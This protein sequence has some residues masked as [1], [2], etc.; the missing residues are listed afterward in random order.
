[1]TGT[2]MKTRGAG[3]RILRGGAVV[4]VEPLPDRAPD[5]IDTPYAAAV[6]EK[7]S[8]A[9]A[10]GAEWMYAG[11]SPITFRGCSCPSP[12]FCTDWYRRSF[13]PEAYRHSIA[14]LD[15]NGN[16][17]MHIGQYGNLDSADGPASRIHPGGDGI[18]M[19]HPRAVGA[20]DNYVVF[21]SWEEWVTALAIGYHA[22][23]TAA[24]SV[25]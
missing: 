4:P 21:S 3:V 10:E 17:V 19:F 5:L 13:V 16:L 6:Y 18:G 22:E 2:F 11:A 15:T 8:W 20:T 14:V 1:M 9:W 7:A 23:E 25:Q 24:I 12:R